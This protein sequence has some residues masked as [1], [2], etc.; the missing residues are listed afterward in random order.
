M[1]KL[2]SVFL[3]IAACISASAETTQELAEKYVSQYSSLAVSEMQRSGVPA[4]ITL[5]Q[6]MLESGFGRSRLAEEG[7]NHF[8]IKCHADWKGESIYKDDDKKNECFRKYQTVEESFRDHSDF[9]R[10]KP[11]YSSLFELEPTDYKGWAYG[12]K[13]AGYATL[14]T[15]PDR[16]IGLIET[17]GLDRFDREQGGAAEVPGQTADKAADRAAGKTSGKNDGQENGKASDKAE[18]GQQSAETAT[19]AAIAAAPS[20]KVPDAPSTLYHPVRYKGERR[21]GTYAVSLDREVLEIGDV[22][23]IYARTGETYKS[24]AVL[25]KYFPHELLRFNDMKSDRVLVSGERVYL[26]RKAKYAARG[27]EKHVCCEGENIWS[28]SQEYAVRESSLL[29]LNGID[30]PS[31]PLREDQTILLRKPAKQTKHKQTSER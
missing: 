5:A 6:G 9:L 26:E 4:S 28:I 7:K 23:F 31:D 25:Y 2:L 10:Y 13:K 19:A 21:R 18:A 30:D 17:Y 8:G 3:A 11:R 14:E 12:L 27:L 24:I 15:Y 22:P 1:K 29:K 16:L 20:V